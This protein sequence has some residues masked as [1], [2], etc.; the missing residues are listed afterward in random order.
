MMTWWLTRAPDEHACAAITAGIDALSPGIKAIL[1]STSVGVPSAL[2]HF[3]NSGSDFLCPDLYLP[4]FFFLL[5]HATN[6]TFAMVVS[7]L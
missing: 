7:C 6:S 3:D 2:R 4:A 1:N 5:E